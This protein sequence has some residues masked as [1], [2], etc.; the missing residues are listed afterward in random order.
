MVMLLHLNTV[1]LKYYDIEILYSQ[2]RP[3]KVK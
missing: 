2:N 1:V 3:L